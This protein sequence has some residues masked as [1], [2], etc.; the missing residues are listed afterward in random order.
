[1]AKLN[2]TL[3]ECSLDEPPVAIMSLNGCPLKSFFKSMSETILSFIIKVHFV[4]SSLDGQLQ[5]VL[6]FVVVFF[7]SIRAT[8]GHT[9]KSFLFLFQSTN[10]L[11]QM[12]KLTKFTILIWIGN[13][14]WL[15][16]QNK[17]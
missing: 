2:Q 9:N 12:N 11:N 3:Q 15:S 16:P 14:R 10:L 4:G 8:T 6:L 1:L 13:P 5:R 17:F 7:L